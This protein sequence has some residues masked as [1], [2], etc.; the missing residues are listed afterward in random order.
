M[1]PKALLALFPI[2]AG[3]FAQDGS[4]SGPTSSTEAA[5]YSCDT[6]KCQLPNCHCASTDPPGGLDP[7]STRPPP[8]FMFGQREV[9]PPFYARKK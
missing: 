6:T 8:R 9:P 2:L 1:L 4:V 5:G 7:V 3:V